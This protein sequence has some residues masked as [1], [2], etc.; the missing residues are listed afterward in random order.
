MSQGRG[1]P[2]LDTEKLRTALVRILPAIAAGDVT[3]AQA[4]RQLGI[5]RRS[6]RRYAQRLMHEPRP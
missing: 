2:S 5:S 4:A 3:K 1:R 6:L